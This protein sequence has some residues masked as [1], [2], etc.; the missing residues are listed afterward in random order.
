MGG[1]LPQGVPSAAS[2]QSPSLLGLPR[3]A[4]RKKPQAE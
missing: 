2:F 3:G 1:R 4:R